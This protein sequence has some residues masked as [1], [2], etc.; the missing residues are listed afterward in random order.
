MGYV[1][2]TISAPPQGI[3]GDANKK[4]PNPEYAT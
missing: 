3:D 2:G 4:I 1:D